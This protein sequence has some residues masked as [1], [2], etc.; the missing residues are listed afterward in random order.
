MVWWARGPNGP[1]NVL[2]HTPFSTHITRTGQVEMRGPGFCLWLWF[3]N[4]SYRCD[5]EKASDRK[6]CDASLSKR[7]LQDWGHLWFWNP[8]IYRQQ[9]CPLDRIH[10]TP[11]VLVIWSSGRQ[12]SPL[13]GFIMLKG[14]D[15]FTS[16][17]L[18]KAGKRS[19]VE[20]KGSSNFPVTVRET[21]GWV[22][23]GGLCCG[24]IWPSHTYSG[25]K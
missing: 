5:Y 21:V 12:L 14:G 25:Q 19:L 20:Y 11:W 24:H 7:R 23:L 22:H 4:I 13:P 2:C 6:F 10:L 18:R 16:D 15:G 9:G 8:R 17:V 3:G 1:K